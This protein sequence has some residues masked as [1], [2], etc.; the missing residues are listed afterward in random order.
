MEAQS[1]KPTE[2]EMRGRE[3]E[4]RTSDSRTLARVYV[5][6]CACVYLS[7]AWANVRSTTRSRKKHK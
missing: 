6:V 7:V 4:K 2:G 1:S 5:C 3:S